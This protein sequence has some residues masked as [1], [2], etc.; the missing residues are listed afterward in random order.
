[1]LIDHG[2]LAVFL[3]GDHG[4]LIDEAVVGRHHG[5]LPRAVTLTDGGLDLGV[6]Q[7]QVSHGHVVLVG[8]VGRVD[9]LGGLLIDYHLLVAAV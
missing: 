7:H 5:L 8:D 4:I 3:Y 9:G 1:M 2:G 6:L